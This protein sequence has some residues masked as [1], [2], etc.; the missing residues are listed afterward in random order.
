MSNILLFAQLWAPA[1]QLQNQ[2]QMLYAL[3][4]GCGPLRVGEALGL[5]IDKHISSD[6]RTLTINQKAKRGIIQ[7]HLKTKNGERLV[8]LCTPLANMLREFVGKRR[9]GLLFT[10]STGAQLLQSNALSDSLHPILDFIA[11]EYGGFNIFRR[12]RLTHVNKFECPESLRRFWS[13]HATGH[14]EQRYIKH[15]HDR[16]FRLMWAEKIGL[17]FELPGASS[18]RCAQ[19]AQLLEFRKAG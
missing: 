13:G 10:S 19:R 3:L 11:H 18:S 7:P 8:D 16:E 1:G 6:F 17:G 4:A 5:E 12:F 9:S 15:E 2:Y 14:V